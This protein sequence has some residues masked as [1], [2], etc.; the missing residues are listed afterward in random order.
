[1]NEWDLMRQLADASNSG[2]QAALS[3]ILTAADLTGW[4]RA[5]D[6]ALNGFLLTDE[7]LARHPEA[8]KRLAALPVHKQWG[9][10]A[11]MRHGLLRANLKTKVSSS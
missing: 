4:P 6:I 2:D 1:M 3:E 10:R 9:L 5:Q 7:N 11:T 8:A